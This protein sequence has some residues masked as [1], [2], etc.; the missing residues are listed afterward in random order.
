MHALPLLCYLCWKQILT[1]MYPSFVFVSLSFRRDL[2]EW[3]FSRLRLLRRPFRLVYPR[4]KP[5]IDVLYAVTSYLVHF[6]GDVEPPWPDSRTFVARRNVAER[7]GHDYK[8][9]LINFRVMNLYECAPPCHC[10]HLNRFTPPAIP[11]ICVYLLS[12]CRDLWPLCSL[13]CH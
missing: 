2:V 7:Q 13:R 9:T 6:S 4:S 10:G 12:V 11:H 3:C 5:I 8:R 1:R